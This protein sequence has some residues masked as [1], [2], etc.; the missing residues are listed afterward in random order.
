V[1]ESNP[2]YPV[3][4]I[5][6]GHEFH[7]SNPVLTGEANLDFVFKV[8]RGH[9]VDGERDGICM[10]NVL[11]TFTHIHA[12]GNPQWAKGLLKASLEYRRSNSR[13]NG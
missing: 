7:Y 3:G 13:K 5:L 9:G 8:R 12:A 11:A 10:K 4:E 6:K 2:Y 1:N